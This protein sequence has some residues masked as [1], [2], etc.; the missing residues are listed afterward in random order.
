MEINLKKPQLGPTK[1]FRVID[2]PQNDY[3]IPTNESSNRYVPYG[4]Y[5]GKTY[6]Y[7]E[8]EEPDD[9]LRDISSSDITS[10]ESEYEEIDINDIY[11]YKSPKYKTLIEVVLKPSSKT[12]YDDTSKYQNDSSNKLTNEEWNELKEDF[13]S[14]YLQNIP[15]DLPNEN[16]IDDKIYMDTQPNIVDSSMEEKPFI[17]SIQDR[18]LYGDSENIYNI[19]WNIPKN[20]S[21][22][23]TDYP[24]YV[25][26]NDK[27]SGIDLINDS[28]NNDQHIDIYDE[29]LKRKENELYGTKHT[30]HTSTNRIAKP[31]SIDPISNQIELFNKWLDRHRDMCNQWNNKEEM[32]SKLNE[33][34]NNEN[35]EHELGITPSTHDDINRINDEN[36]NIINTNTQIN[37]ERNDITSLE[38]LG[39]TN[40][41][42]NDITRNN[43]GF[44][45]KN[46]RTNI[47][48]DILMDENNDITNEDDQLENS[49]NF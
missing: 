4:K 7:V 18:V 13:I 27:Y 5:K 15:K 24:K 37:N 9:Y 36:Y 2:I 42:P 1:L 31:I 28:L 16:I 12:T 48:M 47:S 8:G 17:T 45:T 20:I 22:N 32:L 46:L 43:N 41:P 40:I 35:K 34:W 3:S 25:T 14:Q 23:T 21:S 10:S 11:P 44:R 33:E 49:Y 6:I 39:S 38:H 30:K 19:N 26:S 29:L